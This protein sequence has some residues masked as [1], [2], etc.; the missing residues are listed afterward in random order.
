MIQFDDYRSILCLDGVL[1]DV[2]FF[3]KSRLPIIAADGAANQLMNIGI[4]PLLVIGDL[5]SIDRHLLTRLNIHLHE[6]Q[7]FCDFEKALMYMQ[8]NQL[9]PCIIVGMNGGFL[10]HILNN[11]SVFMKT[12]DQNVLYAPPLYGYMI[13]ASGDKTFHLP[14]HTKISLLAMPDANVTTEG[15]KW[16][17]YRSDL[18]FPGNNSCF[19]QSIHEQIKIS[20]DGGNLIVLIYV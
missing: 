10:D 17:L 2:D 5:D 16:E 20:V 7:N 14:R 1:P 13:K 9:L 8:A 12:N 19:N 11:I 15:L 18:K 4:E 6:D 3:R